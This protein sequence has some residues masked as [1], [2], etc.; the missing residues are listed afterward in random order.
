MSL[1]PQIVR[2]WVVYALSDAVVAGIGCW[3][4]T[5]PNERL[6]ECI[7]SFQDGVVAFS[8]WEKGIA[9][10]TEV[11]K[12]EVEYSEIQEV[13]LINL[14]ELVKIRGPEGRSP[15]R[16][17]VRDVEQAVFLPLKVYSDIGPILK[18]IVDRQGTAVPLD[19]IRDGWPIRTSGGQS[20]HEDD[21]DLGL[22]DPKVDAVY[23]VFAE[24]RSA[25]VGRMRAH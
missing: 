11:Q 25:V 10:Q 17:K 7:Y 20:G 4:T 22:L 14:R 21:D 3:A 5:G 1:D 15:L 23:T 9:Y 8:V 16:F 6:G 18:K 13:N 2:A 12:T 24:F 19:R